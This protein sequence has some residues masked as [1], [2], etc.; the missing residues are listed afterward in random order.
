MSEDGLEEVEKKWSGLR[1]SE[2]LF[3][4]GGWLSY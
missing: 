4:P 1:H 2:M 3:R